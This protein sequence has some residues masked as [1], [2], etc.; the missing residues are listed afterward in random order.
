MTTGQLVTEQR[1][2]QLV[3]LDITNSGFVAAT[4]IQYNVKTLISSFTEAFIPGSLS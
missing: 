2:A 1:A 4:A 3:D